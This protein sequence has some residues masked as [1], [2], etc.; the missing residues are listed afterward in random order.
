M[1]AER[2]ADDLARVEGRVHA[3]EG[4]LVGLAQTEGGE[5][6]VEE[7]LRSHFHEWRINV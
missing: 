2:D 5:I 7:A 3:I 1:A 6:P 4:E